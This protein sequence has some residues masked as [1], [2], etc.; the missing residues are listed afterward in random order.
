MLSKMC[1]YEGKIRYTLIS[2]VIGS[3]WCRPEHQQATKEHEDDSSERCLSA[4]KNRIL[5]TF[6]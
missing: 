3:L 5:K 1:I 2:V 6:Q 4:A